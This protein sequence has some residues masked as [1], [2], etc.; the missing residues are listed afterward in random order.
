MT[1]THLV[2]KRSKSSIHFHFRSKIPKDLISYFNETKQFQ[3]SLNN[4]RNSETLLVSLRLK[5]IVQ[6]LYSDIRS[7]MKNLTLEDIK[8]ILRIEV[9]KS[10]LYSHQVNE[11][12]NKHSERGVLKGVEYVLDLEQKLQEKVSNNL[13]EYRNEVEVKLEGILK[14]LDITVDKGAV[15]FKKLR[16]RFIDLYLMRTS[17]IKD[18]VNSSGR[19]DDD[20][21]REVDEKLNTNLFPELTEKLTP[22]IENDHYNPI[23]EPSQPYEVQQSLSPHKSTPIS[24]GIDKFVGEKSNITNKSVWEI[25]HTLDL[26]IQEFGDISLG[27]LNREMC[28]K[29]KDDLQKLP[30]NRTKLPQYRDLDFHELVKL[31]VVE[32]DRISRTT[33]NNNL[34]Y[35]SSFM[36][37]CVI[38]GYV[39]INFFEGMRLKK[40]IRVR[41]ER[42]R[43][44]EKELKQIFQKQN[45]IEFTEVE[46]Q[47]YEYYWCPLISLF[48]G[49]RLNEICSLYLDNII[50]VKG[51]H[52][53]KRWCFNILEEPDRPDKHLKTLSSRRIVPIH[54]I[55]ID[56]NFLEF[57][58]LLK[59]RHKNRQRLFQELKL[60][61]GSYIRNVSRFFNRRYLTK[62]GLKTERKTFHSLRHTV[63]D[64]L[65]QQGID[66]SFI[67]ELVGHSSGNIDLDRY[68]KGY[69]SDILYNKCV[70]KILYQTSQNRGID[71]KS[72]KIDW[73]KII[74]TRVW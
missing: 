60:S 51:N 62:L 5:S 46:K 71:F 36:K 59:Q 57:V 6:Q 11:E 65:K 44:E 4:V 41:D 34:G 2:P 42:D 25:R 49:M 21:K 17:W 67:N 38:N 23:P 15:D 28:V 32:K 24:I 61:E 22:I 3:I 30:K 14:S 37:W 56:L 40:L 63:I 66:V 68:G 35:V 26:L 72:L 74:T 43:F 29:F 50:Q 7:G 27:R 48:S 10:I 64:H 1:Y 18:L 19:S 69:N 55:L 58:E 53:E 70:K 54:D 9:R 20:F 73:K 13:G 47:K 39:D 31:N 45:Y 16:N 33:V 8:E 52:R 12:T